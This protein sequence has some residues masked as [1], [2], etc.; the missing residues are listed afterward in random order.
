M[1]TNSSVGR[2]RAL[3]AGVFLLCA[4]GQ[5]F[6][7]APASE[8]QTIDG[9]SVQP[10]DWKGKIVVMSFSGTWVPLAT[11]ELPALQKLADRYASRGVQ[12]FWVSVNS[13]KPGA[14]T[15]STSAD[16]QAFAQKN[17]LRLP[18]LRDP[19]QKLYKELGL[20]GLP[21]IVIL[22]R[23]GKVVRKHVG[24]GV[25]AGEAYGEIIHDLDQLL[26]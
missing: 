3:L 15:Y 13:E 20:D 6:G 21:T 18:V 10:A 12:V 17:G 16:L 1:I 4:A 11:K 19:E 5:A 9:K 14:R 7:Q 24:L 2:I 26:K 25:E 22:D 8:L 23:Q